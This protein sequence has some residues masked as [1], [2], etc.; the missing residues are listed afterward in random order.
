MTGWV[1]RLLGFLILLFLIRRVLAAL[2]GSLRSA[3]QPRR[4]ITGQMVRDPQCGAFVDTRLALVDRSRGTSHYFCS[5]DCRQKFT[6]MA[7]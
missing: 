7:G 3:G 6:Q 1:L 5:E 2:F 4:T